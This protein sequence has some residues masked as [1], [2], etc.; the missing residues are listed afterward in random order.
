MLKFYDV[1]DGEDD[2]GEFLSFKREVGFLLGF[3]LL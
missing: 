1:E 3:V 2:Y